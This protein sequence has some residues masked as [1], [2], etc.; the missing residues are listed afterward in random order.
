MPTPMILTPVLRYWGFKQH[1]F[2]DF[3]LM[4]KRLRL[5]VNREDELHQLHN[6]LSNRLSAVYGSQGVG[7]SSFLRM[8]CQR[9]QK[10]GLSV[11]YVHMTGTS[12]NSLYRE[13]LAAI[14]RCHINGSIK[15]DKRLKLDSKRELER[16]ELSIRFAREAELGANLVIKGMVKEVTEKQI[17]KHTEESA[18]SLIS[19][20][21]FNTKS[22]FVVIIDDLERVKLFAEN[23]Q[24]YFKFI[25]SFARTIDE[26]FSH[27]GVAFVVSLDESFV[28]TI[29]QNLPGDEGAISF[30]FGEL[31]ELRSFPP[32]HL[33]QMIRT[34]LIKR[35][36]N[37]SLK[38]FMTQDA[39]Y[40]LAI[41][42]GGHPRR[43]LAV[44]RT[45][46]E[47]V[48]KN[49]K[50]RQLDVQSI[51]EALKKRKESLDE[52]DSAIIGFIL[53][54]GPRSASDK[55]I[56]EQV[57]LTRNALLT[58]LKGLRSQLGIRVTQHVSGTTTKDVYSVPK[59]E[60]E[61]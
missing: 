19:D 23:E 34:R 28:N 8:F 42:T 61:E 51:Q 18:C 55:D 31:V 26:L 21:I 49:K 37:K 43:A 24:N 35:S 15:T 30:S 57:G 11:A 27:E 45:A 60:F 47:Y 12:E 1:P 2:D 40:S 13:I 52:K 22:A 41:S 58:R 33:L 46:M 9:I 39:F 17:Q 3:I 6:G 25:T 14:L 16:V 32:D 56:Q 38:S 59:V 4:D 54:H 5:F 44:L 50:P 53:T 10:D 20:I 7:K 29:S 36:Q 48:E